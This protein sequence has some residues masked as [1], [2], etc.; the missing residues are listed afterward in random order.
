ME[1]L[2]VGDLNLILMEGEGDTG[3]EGLDGVVEVEG[4]DACNEPAPCVLRRGRRLAD[5]GGEFTG[6]VS[7]G[8]ETAATVS[9]R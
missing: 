5:R 8:V 4:V 1:P 6:E 3:L 7:V 2:S 9:A